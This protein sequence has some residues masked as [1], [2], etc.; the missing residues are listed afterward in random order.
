M[1]KLLQFE[2]GVVE[3]D[4]NGAATVRFNPADETFTRKLYETVAL[5]EGIQDRT[6]SDST[7]FDSFGDLDAEMREAIDELLG[8]GVADALFPGM[9]CYAIADGFPVWMNLVMALV[10]EV[11]EAYAR[12]FGKTDARIKAYSGKYDAM[13]AKYRKGKK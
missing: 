4:I 12:E 5:L 6:A 7:P 11:T 9:N 3:Y 8:E 2:T 10:D 13:F 1:A